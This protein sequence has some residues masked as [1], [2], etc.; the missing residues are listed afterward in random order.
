MNSLDLHGA[1]VRFPGL[2]VF[3]WAVALFVAATT[4]MAQGG[5]AAVNGENLHYEVSGNGTPLVLIH[6]WSLNLRM[7][8]PQV[9]AL[10]RR[11][12]VIRYD[13]RG[14]GESSGSEDITW[15]AADLVALLDHLGATK[16]HVL[17]MSQGARVALQF[18]RDHPDRV[19]SLVLHGAPPPDG[20][21]LPWSGADRPR[22]DE[23]A[24]IAREQGLSAFRSAWQAHP[25][26]KIPA[27]NADAE[28]S[29]A[30]LL[31]AYRGGRFSSP[32]AAPGPVAAITMDELPRVVA[33]TLVLIGDGEVPFL[34]VVGRA[35]V[36][37]LPSARLAVVPGGGHL[38]NLIEPARY[39][40]A[41]LGFL[42]GIGGRSR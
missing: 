31:A 12:R 41:V 10:S 2:R 34:Q 19:S 20:F 30:K 33:P 26:M 22:F 9:A 14:F 1:S 29:V 36:Y 15:D 21:G 42:S 16:V 4:A 24:T 3:P 39:N 25:M 37:Y 7:W 40:A 8:D 5:V 23:W 38:V 18:A 17:G 6:G 13:R 32:K 11:F 35:L 28:A 27:G